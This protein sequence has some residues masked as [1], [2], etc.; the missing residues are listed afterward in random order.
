[1][2]DA[3][4]LLHLQTMSREPAV[5]DAALLFVLVSGYVC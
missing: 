1:M 2:P 5:A 4:V 3:D